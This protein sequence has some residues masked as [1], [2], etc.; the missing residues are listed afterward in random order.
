MQCKHNT[1]S[2]L[3]EIYFLLIVALPFFSYSFFTDSFDSRKHFILLVILHDFSAQD[4]IQSSLSI[5]KVWWSYILHDF[6][7]QF[8]HQFY[9]IWG[10]YLWPH[11]FWHHYC[12]YCQHE[13]VWLHHISCSYTLYHISLIYRPIESLT[14]WLLSHDFKADALYALTKE[15]V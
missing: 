8:T 7:S 6:Y 9:I 14:Q 13:C 5:F 12:H 3:S 4:S 10:I 1:N 11:N 2:F 15:L